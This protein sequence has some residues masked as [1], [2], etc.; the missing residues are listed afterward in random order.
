MLAWDTLDKN[1]IKVVYRVGMV[2]CEL[3]TRKAETCRSE[4]KSSMGYS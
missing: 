2:A 3:N 4:F 1:E